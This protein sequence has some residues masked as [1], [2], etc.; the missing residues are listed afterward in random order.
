MRKAGN[1]SEL[2]CLRFNVFLAWSLACL[3]KMRGGQRVPYSPQTRQVSSCAYAY[4]CVCVCVFPSLSHG[5]PG[6][7][8]CPQP[9]RG[10]GKT[11]GPTWAGSAAGG[12]PRCS[13]FSAFRKKLHGMAC[14]VTRTPHGV[15]GP[16][17]GRAQQR[18]WARACVWSSTCRKTDTKQKQTTRGLKSPAPSPPIKVS[19]APSPPKSFCRRTCLER[20]RLL[21]DLPTRPEQSAWTEATRAA[22]R[23]R[24]TFA[25]PLAL[26]CREA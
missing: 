17:A 23:K 10:F 2:G 26:S 19:P 14:S 15:S 8:N 11:V 12:I 21:E 13:V 1:A 3:C 25:R 6:P 18:G 16:S 9:A 24:E 20:F 22:S 7:H 5:A 4:V